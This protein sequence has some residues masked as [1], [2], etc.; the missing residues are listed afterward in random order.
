[1]TAGGCAK[2]RTF[3][4]GKPDVKANRLLEDEK[5]PV[6]QALLTISAGLV[7][8]LRQNTIDLTE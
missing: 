1:L 6:S 7:R 3:G 2:T 4:V 5:T 8:Q